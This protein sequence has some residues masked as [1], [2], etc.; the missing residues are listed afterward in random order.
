ML[1]EKLKPEKNL[2]KKDV[3]RASFFVR[4]DVCKFSERVSGV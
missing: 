3:R 2:R 4:V 1:C